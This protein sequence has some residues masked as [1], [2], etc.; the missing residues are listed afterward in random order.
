VSK[1]LWRGSPVAWRFHGLLRP[2]DDS[3]TLSKSSQTHLRP[4]L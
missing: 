1:V 3:L 4:R 2:H